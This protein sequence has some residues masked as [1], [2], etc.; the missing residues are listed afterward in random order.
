MGNH[1]LLL[2]SIVGLTSL[3]SIRPVQALPIELIHEGK[4]TIAGTLNGQPFTTD[5]IR[6]VAI[7]DTD[8]R[9]VFDILGNT[10]YSTRHNSSSI[11]INGLG[12]Y[13]FITPLRT[14]SATKIAVVGLGRVGGVDLFNGPSNIAFTSWDQLVSIG[15][16]TGNGSLLQ[17]E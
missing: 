1:R 3:C 14:F 10:G 11:Q 7:A 8:N 15:P 6:I 4:G 5:S 16:V 13:E 2:A 17:W 9:E 12:S